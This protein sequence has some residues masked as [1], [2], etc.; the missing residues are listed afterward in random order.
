MRRMVDLIATL[1]ETSPVKTPTYC[2]KLG[3]GHRTI[4][5]PLLPAFGTHEYD[6][7]PATSLGPGFMATFSAH[8]SHNFTQ[9]ELEKL[10]AWVF[11]LPC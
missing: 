9:S 4:A 7:T 10:V 11:L 5:L 1:H 6:D 3:M 8:V 2:L